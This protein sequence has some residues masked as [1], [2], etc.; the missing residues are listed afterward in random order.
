MIS[1]VI[2]YKIRRT[3]Y[4]REFVWVKRPGQAERLKNWFYQLETIGHVSSLKLALILCNGYLLKWLDPA[5][6]SKM[7]TELQ[8]K[9]ALL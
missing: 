7:K 6:R 1:S 9:L 5:L 3:D 2:G 8:I 4:S